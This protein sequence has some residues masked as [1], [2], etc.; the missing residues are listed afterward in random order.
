[1]MKPIFEKRRK[2]VFVFLPFQLSFK[3]SEL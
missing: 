3:C 2:S 1:M